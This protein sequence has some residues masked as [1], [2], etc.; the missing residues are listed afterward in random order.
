MNS[1]T[2]LVFSLSLLLATAC[3]G[4]GGGDVN[5][6][7]L[8]SEVGNSVCDSQVAC[9]TFPD[10]AACL[11]TLN[12]T[13]DQ[14]IAEVE[15]GLIDY[16][17]VKAGEC[18]DSLGSD[19]SIFGSQ[20]NNDACEDTFV[21]KIVLGGACI[22]SESC[23]GEAVCDESNE[24]T[25]TPGV[26]VANEREPDAK[27]GESCAEVDCESGLLCDDTSTCQNPAG[28]GEACAGF[29][30][31][32]AGYICELGPD[33]TPGTCI[34]VPT[35]GETCDPAFG[36]EFVAGRFS[37]LLS[38]DYCD[39]SDTTC[40]AKLSV[41]AACTAGLENACV[42]YATCVDATCTARPKLGESCVVDAPLE[43]LGGL[44]CE[45]GSCVG[46]TATPVC[47]L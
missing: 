39:P 16:N 4:G 8:G 31:C 7:D 40:K 46:E 14:L 47:T 15:A 18:L 37:C 32:I 41:G 25:C 6:E 22:T 24:E 35:T 10:K 2:T 9:G 34:K 23:A 5:I 3:G 43:C 17:S 27:A 21:G 45:S 36:G 13:V 12:L 26:C 42:N 33:F 38:T 11:E 19:C 1:A 44:D 30:E 29:D 28:S 20:G